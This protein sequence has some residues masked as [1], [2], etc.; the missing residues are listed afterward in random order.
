MKTKIY[1][2]SQTN[3]TKDDYYYLHCYLH[4]ML[5]YYEKYSQE[6]RMLNI[7]KMSAE[8]KVLMY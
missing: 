5:F 2:E 3:W 4:R 1:Y 6:I 7:E 8:T